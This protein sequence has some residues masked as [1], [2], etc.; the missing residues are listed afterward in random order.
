MSTIRPLGAAFGIALLLAACGKTPSATGG[1]A[2]P[3]RPECIA[4]A[5]PGGSFDLT[6]KLAQSAL[7]QADLLSKPMR[8]TYMPGGVG[9]VAYNTVVAQRPADGNAITA[10]SSGSLLN[11]AQG[12]F[13]QYDENAVRWL[14]AVG[15]SYGAIVV[16]ADAPYRNLSDL[17]KALQADPEKVVIGAAGTVGG[18]DWMQTALL[19]RAAGVKP[20]QL[21]YVAMEGGGEIATA[22]LGGHIQVGSTDVSDSMPH[23][24]SGKLRVLAVLSEQRLPGRAALAT[25]PTAR[26]QGYDVV[27]KVMRGYYVGP[28][29]SEADY[30]FWRDAFDRLLASEDFARL[31]AE[32]EL[33]PLALTGEA[34]QAQVNA[35]VAHY[36]ELAAEFGLVK[37]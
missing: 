34:L 28:Q 29:V 10:F 24:E 21:R 17:V 35:D 31:R 1:H 13:G 27:W 18:Q 36:R 37:P 30:A 32:R 14:A 25:L 5:S 19:A 3:A 4:P 8:V 22:L 2:P 11:L 15:S 33:F 6:C 20:G 9:A 12:K 16:R 7:V 26:E 23:V